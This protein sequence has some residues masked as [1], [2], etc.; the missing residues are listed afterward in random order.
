MKL[1]EDG[2]TQDNSVF[3]NDTA[4]TSTVFTVDGNNGEPKVNQDGQ[5]YVAYC[6]TGIQGYSKFGKYV[7]N[8]NADGPF[9]YTGFKPA[10]MI[11]K[12]TDSANSWYLVDITRDSANIADH[13]LE[14]NNTGAEATG[15]A[16]LDILSN[17]FKIRTSGAAYNADDGIYIYL[18]F[19]ESP[20]VTSNGGPNN[21]Q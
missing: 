5:T 18:A 20:F 15:T 17:G 19:A 12:R 9:I 4:P 14:A 21:A 10:W 3:W 11:I 16:R 6:F 2:A 7:G 1:D 13:E 8:A